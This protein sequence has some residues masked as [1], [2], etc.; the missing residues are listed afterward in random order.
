MAREPVGGYEASDLVQET[1]VHAGRD[2][3]AFR[4]TTLEEFRRWLTKIQKHRLIDARRH[5]K[6][7]DGRLTKQSVSLQEACGGDSSGQ[8]PAA[9]DRERT[10][11]EAA[12]YRERQEA[13]RRAILELSAEQREVL[14]LRSRDRLTFAE[15]GERLGKTDEAARKIFGRALERLREIL[16]PSHEPD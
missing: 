2:L 12:S 7:F 4:G 1:C 9:V 10:P 14:E 8:G 11:S 6:T 13:L 3:S 5:D 15:I 16:G